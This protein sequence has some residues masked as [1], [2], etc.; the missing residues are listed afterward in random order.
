MAH[1]PG[2]IEPL[3]IDVADHLPAVWEWTPEQLDFEL[4]RHLL[5]HDP[6]CFDLTGVQVA[7]DEDV[8]GAVN[9]LKESQFAKLLAGE[10][11]LDAHRTD[12]G[13]VLM[14]DLGIVCDTAAVSAPARA[15][16]ESLIR[17]VTQGVQ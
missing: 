1:N 9:S 5:P 15:L 2:N 4:I 12:D 3:S 7:A 6:N 11:A 17:N 13:S 14:E 16:L 8:M 10:V